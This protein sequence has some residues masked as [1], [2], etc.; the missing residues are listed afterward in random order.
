MGTDGYGIGTDGYGETNYKI[1]LSNTPYKFEKSDRS[2]TSRTGPTG[3]YHT[4]AGILINRDKSE[5]EA[6]VVAPV[7]RV[8]R[9]P[10]RHTV[11]PAQHAARA[12]LR[13]CGI[14]HCVS[15]V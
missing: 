9:V 3:L 2:D 10:V 6:V 8:V 11:A 1:L 13:S 4:T 12:F 7:V 15:A 5:A 14:G